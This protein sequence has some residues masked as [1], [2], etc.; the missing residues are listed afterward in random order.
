MGNLRLDGRIKLKRILKELEGGAFHIH[1]D[2][3]RDKRPAFVNAV[4]SHRVS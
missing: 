1:L 4:M 2:Q 3:E